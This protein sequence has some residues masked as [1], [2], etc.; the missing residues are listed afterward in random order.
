M[1]REDDRGPEGERPQPE[2]VGWKQTREGPS[3]KLIG[4]AVVGCLLLVFVLQNADR[5]DV[6]FL[7]WDGTSP[8]WVVILVAAGLGFVG[9]WFLGRVRRADRRAERAEKRA[10]GND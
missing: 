6:D 9:G 8:L 1:R 5:A 3:G 10:K 2:H 7:I 4:A